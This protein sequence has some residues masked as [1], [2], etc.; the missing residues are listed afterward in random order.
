MRQSQT[1]KAEE[2]TPAWRISKPVA[3]V[4]VG[5]VFDRGKGSQRIL[6]FF[7]S[8]FPGLFLSSSSLSSLLK[9]DGMRGC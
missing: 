1:P 9:G 4:V 7:S 3:V 8:R 6:G 5:D 2:I